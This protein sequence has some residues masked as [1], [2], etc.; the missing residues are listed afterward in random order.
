MIDLYVDESCQNGHHYMVIGGIVTR[1]Q[2]SALVKELLNRVKRQYSIGAEVKWVKV[3]E[4]S[5]PCYTKLID[6]FFIL[7]SI[8]KVYFHCLVVDCHQLQH[9]KF[10]RGDS[11]VGFS[12]FL[13]QL[14]V[15]KFGRTYGPLGPIYTYLDNRATRQ[16]LEELRTILNSGIAKR[17][18]IHSTP[19]RHLSFEDSKNNTILQTNDLILGAIAYHKN[20]HDAAPSV[21]AYK[22]KLAEHIAD[23]LNVPRLGDNLYVPPVSIWNFRLDKRK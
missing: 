14:L 12:K 19:F 22:K 23:K 15:H 10:N 9:A 7:S 17:W 18:N 11:E 5:L 3:S 4:Y 1:T 6:M 8:R 13:Y 2:N 21:G 20:H 16:S